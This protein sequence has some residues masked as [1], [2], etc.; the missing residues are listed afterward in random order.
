[1]AKK[2]NTSPDSG[3]TGMGAV[4][5]REHRKRNR[6]PSDVA[7]PSSAVPA[8]P[9]SDAGGNEA[10]GAA[11]APS[12]GPGATAPDRAPEYR[13]IAALAYSY[14]EARGGQGGSPEDDWLRAERALCT[15][16]NFSAKA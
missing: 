3:V 15:G 1:M 8:F 7:S 2:R 9:Q 12:P 11:A 13:E 10:F 5:A 16:Q 6:I 4:P 14:W